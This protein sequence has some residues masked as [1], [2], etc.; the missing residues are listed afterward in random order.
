MKL[1]AIGI[2]PQK[3]KQFNGKGIFSVEDMVRYLPRKYN[4]F[5]RETGILPEDQISC[6]IVTVNKVCT[7][8][9]GKPLMI[10]FCETEDGKRIF[11]KWFHQNYLAAKYEE[12]VGHKV[13]LCAK[14]EY[15]AEYDNYSATSPEMFEPRISIGKRIIPV[16][17]KIPGMSMD[18]RC[19]R[20]WLRTR[21]CCLSGS[22]DGSHASP[23]QTALCR[24]MRNSGAGRLPHRVSR[25]QHE[26][27]GEEGC[28]GVHCE[29]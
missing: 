29:R 23:C 26:S 12:F 4:D 11:V 3:E 21:S 20:T 5:S 13:Y 19:L 24:P 7:Y 2:T 16:Y 9:N 15:S 25:F 27:E 14:L 17:S 8:N 22:P 1:S 18:R 10:V 6:L 28:S